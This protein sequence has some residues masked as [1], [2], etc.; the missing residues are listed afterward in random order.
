M[1]SE[2][3]E[4]SFLMFSGVKEKANDMKHKRRKVITLK[5]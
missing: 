3:R 1:A 2:E 4:I 5:T